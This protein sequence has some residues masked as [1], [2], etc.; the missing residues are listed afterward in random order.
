[1]V[2]LVS[3]IVRKHNTLVLSCLSPCD[4]FGME[5]KSTYTHCLRPLM[6]TRTVNS[7]LNTF[8]YNDNW[9]MNSK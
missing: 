7:Y 8:S 3:A 2:G 4:V 5:G 9:L 6:G 1:M